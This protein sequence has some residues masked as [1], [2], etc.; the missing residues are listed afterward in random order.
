[1][2]KMILS[3][4]RYIPQAAGNSESHIRSMEAYLA[5]MSEEL[6]VLLGEAAGVLDAVKAAETQGSASQNKFEGGTEY[7]IGEKQ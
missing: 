4:G 2:E 5:R 1:M 7:G 6:E 3:C